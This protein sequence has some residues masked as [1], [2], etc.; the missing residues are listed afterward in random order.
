SHIINGNRHDNFWEMGDTGP[1]GPCSEIHIDLRSDEERAE[2]D[3]ASLVNKD[4]P[5][6]I[7]IWNLVFMQ[8]ERK[9]DGHLE[10]L[11]AKVIDTGMGFER[12]CM[13]LQGKKSNYD[14]DVF[15]PYIAKI[16]EISGKEYGKDKMVDVAMRVCS[17]HC[18]TIAF[19]IADSQLPSNAKAGYVIR[20]ILRRAVRYAYTFLDQKNPFIY[21]LVDVMV[22]QM[23]E[24]YPEL[25]AQK[26]LIKKVIKEEEESF[27]RTLD[28]GIGL[29]DNLVAAAKKEGKTEISGKDAFTLYDTYG[30]PL[31]LTELILR[32]QGMTLD[33]KGY[34]EEM[35][36]QKERARNAAAIETGDWVILKDGE[37]KFVGY[38]VTENESR[39]LRYRKV[40]QKGKEFFQI[41]LD[42]TPFYGEMGG[43]VGDKGKLID[44]N[45]EE[46]EIFDTK[47]ENNVSVHLSYKLPENPADTFKAVIDTD[48]RAA[49]SANHSATHLL[50]EALREVLGTH[51][52]QK[53]S[54]VSPES[55]RFDFS[56]FQKVTPEELRKVEHLVNARI[57]KAM[58]LDE[59]R[60]MPI[61]EAKALGAMALFGEKYGDKVR[62]VKFGDSVELCGGTHVANTGNIGMVRIVSESSIAAGIRR[63]EAVSGAG[64]E[65]IID[66][67]QDLVVGL[68]NLL[69]TN[70]NIR[71]AV[72]KAVKE[73]GELRKQVEEAMAER[74]NNLA[75]E[76]LDKAKDTNGVK[77]VE[78]VGVNVPDVV[79]NV[80]FTIRK[81]SPEHTVFVGATMSP[82]KKPLLTVM[83]SDDLVKNGSNAGQIVREAAKLIKG[84]GGGQPFFA[85]AGG[86]DVEGLSAARD[87]IIELLAL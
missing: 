71:T 26:D 73:N 56:H 78:L 22:D 28:K 79:K 33:E 77:V 52:E 40:K 41:I 43:Q 34:Q 31:D 7:E 80:A 72:E 62:V 84:G 29:L 49:I 59:H 87:K 61:A 85:Q 15:T 51:V 5:Q 21:Q 44:S 23:G 50:H 81:K 13:A 27:L 74:I 20:R 66:N 18:R 1:C 57:R 38:D 76:L 47:R 82:D 4:N 37:Q 55:L 9:A 48:A 10:P 3:G 16:S 65:N 75:S 86:K 83:L 67:F 58:P 11:P 32:E 2:V 8:Y 45:G 30:F 19:S 42:E 25:V 53:G 54:Y 36:R 70:G 35:N 39:I 12:L 60:D 69:G 14:T 6:V 68:S 24:A 64:V 17:D 46:I 63:I